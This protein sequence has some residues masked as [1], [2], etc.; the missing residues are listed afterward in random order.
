MPCPAAIRSACV[1]SW[2]VVKI[3]GACS[4]AGA[5]AIVTLFHY[6]SPFDLERGSPIRMRVFRLN[7][8]RH[9]VAV[10]MHHIVCDGWSLGVFVRDA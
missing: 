1:S 7:P 6:D 3:R 10:T 8:Q 9:V 4:P 5:S 2:L